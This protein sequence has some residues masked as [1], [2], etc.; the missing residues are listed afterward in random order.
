[1]SGIE[2]PDESNSV[3]VLAWQCYAIRKEKQYLFELGC[4]LANCSRDWRRVSSM[5]R[6]D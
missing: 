4:A 2:L 3:V 6:K 5:E 1:M